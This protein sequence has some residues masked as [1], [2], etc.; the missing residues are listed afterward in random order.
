VPASMHGEMQPTIYCF[1]FGGLEIT[2]IMDS[3]VIRQGC[4]Q[5]SGLSTL[6]STRKSYVAP[7]AS[8]PTAT[9]TRL[10]RRWSIP[11]NS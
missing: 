11:A 9:S 6:P 3:K 7:T 5:A 8:T 4:I 2:N 10:S 1:K